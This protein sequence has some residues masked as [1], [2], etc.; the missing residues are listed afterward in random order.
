MRGECRDPCTTVPPP[1]GVGARCR[2]INHRTI[3]QCPDGYEGDPRDL[4]SPGNPPSSACAPPPCL[5]G[6]SLP[7][8]PSWVGS[9]H[10]RLRMTSDLD[11]AA[12]VCREKPPTLRRR[13]RAHNSLTF[14]QH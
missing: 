13:L 10:V 9:G 11:Y 2:V 14:T 6:A 8:L 3:C 1:C 7:L 4:C 12:L 5:L